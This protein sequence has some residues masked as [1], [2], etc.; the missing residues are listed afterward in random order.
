MLARWAVL[1]A[2]LGL[3]FPAA[4][5]DNGQQLSAEQA[6][7]FV[8]GKTFAYSCFEGTRGA[9]RISPDGAVAGTIQMGGSGPLRAAALPPGTLQVRG[10]KICASVKGLLFDP[11]F[12]VQQTS[13]RSFRGSISGF[14]FAY[15]EFTQFGHGRG[16]VL[17][18]A[19]P[20]SEKALGLR[21][22]IS[23]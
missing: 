15:C 20:A 9:G 16:R 12:D 19:A 1:L 17:R 10:P 21:S 14:G 2:G 22:S 18:T 13:A 8:V 7:Q 23:D 5:Q 6:R 4:A 3:A 11:C